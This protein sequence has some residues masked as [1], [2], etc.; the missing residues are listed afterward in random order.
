M[1]LTEITFTYQHSTIENIYKLSNVINQVIEQWRYN[2]QIIGREI[3]MFIAQQKSDRMYAFIARVVCPEQQSLYPEFNNSAVDQALEKAQQL[4]IM[5]DSLEVLGQ[6]LNSD[7]T[8]YHDTYEG[9]QPYWQ[10]LYTTYLKSCSPLY[11]GEDSQRMNFLPIPLYRAFK[12][13]PHLAMDIIKWQ[14]NWQAYDQLQMNAAALE[15]QAVQELSSTDSTLFKHGYALCREI[16]A[17]TKVP[18]YYYLYRVGG[19]SLEEEEK[20]KCPMCGAKW[21]LTKP[22]CNVIHFKCDHCRLL[23][24]ISWNWL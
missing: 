7:D 10:M 9:Q 5:F 3:P 21:R 8:Y 11:T 14:E 15:D 13:A 19:K 22:L 1:F 2:G 16:E 18:T 17:H 24:N 12:D 23:S 20:R 4:G 6:D